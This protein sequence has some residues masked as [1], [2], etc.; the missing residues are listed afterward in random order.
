MM[1]PY[2][3][4]DTFGEVLSRPGRAT[5]VRELPLTLLKRAHLRDQ[6]CVPLMTRR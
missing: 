5:Q 2:P 3:Q 4:A 6:P 1:L